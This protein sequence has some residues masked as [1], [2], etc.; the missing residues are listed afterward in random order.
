MY[1]NNPNIKLGEDY[2][3]GTYSNVV[4]YVMDKMNG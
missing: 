2:W 3:H 1:S 4:L